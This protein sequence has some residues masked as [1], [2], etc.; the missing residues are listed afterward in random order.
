MIKKIR[1]R[2]VGSFQISESC[3]KK[4]KTLFSLGTGTQGSRSLLQNRLK[5]KLRENFPD[6]GQ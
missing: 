5:S 1:A 3:Y 4:M 2:H 6:V